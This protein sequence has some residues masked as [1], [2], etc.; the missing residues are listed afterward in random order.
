MKR[1][2]YNGCDLI[3]SFEAKAL[4]S[5]KKLGLITNMSGVTRELKATSKALSEKYCLKALFGPEHGIRGAAQDGG[6]D[7]NGATAPETKVP[8]YDLFGP[9]K[10]EAQQI[11][12]TLD[13][14]VFDIQDI[15]VRYYT[16][17]FTLLDS[18]RLAAKAKI[19]LIVL[20][21][22]NPL[23]GVNIRG[24]RIDEDCV[25]GVGAVVSQPALCG[26]TMGELALWFNSHLSIGADISVIRC[27]GWTR[28]IWFDDTD[29]LFVPPSP[30][31]PSLD[32]NILYPGTCFFEGTAVSEG[33][34][35][36]KPFELFGAPWMNPNKVIDA[37]YSLKSE[38]KETFSGIVMRPCAFTPT[39]HKYAGELCGGI[40]LHVRDRNA[41]DA[42]ALGLYL[43]QVIRELYP[44]ECTLNESLARLVGTKKVFSKDFDTYEYLISQKADLESFKEERKPYLLY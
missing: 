43:L 36:T 19:P 8:I 9:G 2:V 3:D 22:I 34:G 30:N 6:H 40:Q 20:D 10:A 17:Q 24:N 33:R 35:T 41:L 18:M 7:G 25:S 5:G 23:G 11:F 28:D 27:D 44:N 26:M 4:L 29:L 37:M 1:K 39:F 32:T 42:Y 12:S 13:A 31:M 38:A 21:R 16:Y 15:G 14:I